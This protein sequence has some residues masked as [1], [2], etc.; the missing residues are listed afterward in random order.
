MSLVYQSFDLLPTEI[1]LQIVSKLRW[2]YIFGPV[3]E[4]NRQ[5]S[6][7]T[8]IY[9]LRLSVGDRIIIIFEDS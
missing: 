2:V 1:W 3:L 8:Q 5:I 7:L 4:S 6:D 9:R